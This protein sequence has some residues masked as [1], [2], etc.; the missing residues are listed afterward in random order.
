MIRFIR[1]LL[2]VVAVT[3]T[4]FALVSSPALAVP[5]LEQS[6][7]PGVELPNVEPNVVSPVVPGP[8]DPAS[9]E[10]PGPQS[11]TGSLS[12]SATDSTTGSP[13]TGASFSLSTGESGV[14]PGTVSGLAA[15]SV[16]VTI[17]AP[18]GMS[19]VGSASQTATIVADQTASVAFQLASTAASSSSSSSPAPGPTDTGTLTIV[20]QDRVSGAVLAGATF[21]VTD[22]SDKPISSVT[23]GAGGTAS[24]T[25]PVGCYRVFETA[26]PAGYFTDATIGQASVVKDG[27]ATLA[28]YDTPIHVI[29]IERD[30][31]NRIPIRSIPSGRIF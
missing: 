29:V 2:A 7:P 15:G 3:A 11:T 8:G 6:V 28:M 27:V 1:A 5:D 22:C 21:G 30:P 12:V 9:P 19:V 4:A 13:V 20:K 26:A 25:V 31:G 16:T 10:E 24:L 14:T 23:T 17:T 18:T